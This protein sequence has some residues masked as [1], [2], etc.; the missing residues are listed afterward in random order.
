MIVTSAPD[1]L[2]SESEADIVRKSFTTLQCPR[3]AAKLSTLPDP[4]IHSDLNARSTKLS[5]LCLNTSVAV[6]D[7]IGCTLYIAG[8]HLSVLK[9]FH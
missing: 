9:C 8:T 5:S 6:P 7:E 3:L 2:L 4:E 1:M